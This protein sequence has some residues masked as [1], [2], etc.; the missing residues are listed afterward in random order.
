M[1]SDIDGF[2]RIGATV[3]A[4]LLKD[5]KY[6]LVRNHMNFTTWVIEAMDTYVKKNW[7]ER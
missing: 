5:L 1:A 3:P 2:S 6:I 7:E 4:E